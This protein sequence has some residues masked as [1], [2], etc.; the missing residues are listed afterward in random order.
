MLLV[1]LIE[2]IFVIE[3]VMGIIQINNNSLCVF[4]SKYA[5]NYTSL[6]AITKYKGRYKKSNN[7]QKNKIFLW[8]T[9]AWIQIGWV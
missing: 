4:I 6:H 1:L 7:L 8:C 2:D 3:L 9:V 5:H